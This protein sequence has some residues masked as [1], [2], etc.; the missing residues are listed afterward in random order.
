MSALLFTRRPVCRSA[1]LHKCSHVF[2]LNPSPA[3]LL[4]L[5]SLAALDQVLRDAGES[6]VGE[7]EHAQ[8]L[9]VLELAGEGA[10]LQRRDE[11]EFWV[12]GKRIK[13]VLVSNL[14]EKTGERLS[15]KRLW[16]K[17]ISSSVSSIP[18][19]FL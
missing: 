15:P 18:E 19:T 3:V 8:E 13:Q 6:V 10:E 17:K 4:Y 11:N 5:K 14:V 16:L 2:L 1:M 9:Q 7:V 12:R